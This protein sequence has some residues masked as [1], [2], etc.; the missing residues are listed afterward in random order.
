MN[1][2]SPRIV[3][4]NEIELNGNQRTML[5]SGWSKAALENS[6]VEEIRYTSDGL[7]IKGYLGLPK[8][9]EEEGPYPALIWNRGGVGKNGAIDAFTARGILGQLASWGYV[10]LAS[11]YRGDGSGDGEDEFGGSDVNDIL[12][13]AQ[14]LEDIPEADASRIGMEGWSRGGMMT[15]IALKSMKNVKCALFTGAISDLPLSRKENKTLN[16]KFEKHIKDEDFDEALKK[17]SAVEF[18]EE[19]PEEVPLLIIHGS[20][21]DVVCPQHSLNLAQ[22]LTSLNRDYRLLILEGG[23][24]FLKKHRDEINQQRKTWYQRHLK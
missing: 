8:D 17:R 10:V 11:M 1:D 23:D 13:L 16:S 7:T 14:L 22:K 19:L 9:L 5:S 12:N 2:N 18:A 24:H 4:R 6:V 15:Y 20:A 21:D 3:E